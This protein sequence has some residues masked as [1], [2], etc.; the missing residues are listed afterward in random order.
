MNPRIKTICY[1]ITLL[2]WG[3]TMV[4]F[5]TSGRLMRYL[6]ED[7]RAT[8]LWGGLAMIV[9]G[10]YNLLNAHIPATCEHDH[11]HGHSCTDEGHDHDHSDLHPSIALAAMILPVVGAALISQ[12]AYSAA[13]L[14][15]KGLF[16]DTLSSSTFFQNREA[17][18]RETLEATTEQTED[19]FFKIDLLDIY[20]AIGDEETRA[21]FDGLPIQL[22]GRISPDKDD[23]A[24]NRL[25]LYRVY[26]MC[27]AAD[28][29]PISIVLE[30]PKQAPDFEEIEWL[31]TKG[32]L[33]YRKEEGIDRAIVKVGSYEISE[34][35]NDE[36]LELGQ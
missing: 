31:S 27:C 30:F 16:N 23:A 17:Y 19:G 8:A 33:E 5:Y 36:M 9:L 11:D 18:T 14:E 12:D 25:R 1:S 15:R 20:F 24:H 2:V 3:G 29:R 26:V 7:F 22:E 10:L 13:A 35:P 6:A 32:T 4:Y 34:A 28:S 21:V